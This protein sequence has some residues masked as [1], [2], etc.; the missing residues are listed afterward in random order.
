MQQRRQTLIQWTSR[1]VCGALGNRSERKQQSQD[2]KP[3]DADK[4][5]GKV[6]HFKVKARTQ[7]FL[8]LLMSLF[9]GAEKE[10]FIL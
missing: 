8:K 1:A 4:T 10:R 3:T 7:M 9:D 5:A 2:G 6:F